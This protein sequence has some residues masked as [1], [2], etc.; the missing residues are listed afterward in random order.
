MS[1]NENISRGEHTEHQGSRAD[2]VLKAFQE[3]LNRRVNV[4]SE[5]NGGVIP[6]PLAE[7]WAAL[8]S[9]MEIE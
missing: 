2:R 9:A 1:D 6:G 5:I 8:N 3:E 4:V 7:V